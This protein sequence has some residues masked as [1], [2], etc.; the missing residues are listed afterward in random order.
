MDDLELMVD[1]TI[2]YGETLLVEQPF[3]NDLGIGGPIRDWKNYI[4]YFL[5]N[6][7]YSFRWMFRMS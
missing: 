2:N 1:E 7:I 3:I 6:C 4:S 5:L